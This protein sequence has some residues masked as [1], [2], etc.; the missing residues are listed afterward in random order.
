MKNKI[1]DFRLYLQ[2]LGRLR[3]I[4]IALAILCLTVSIL[5]PTVRWLSGPGSNYQVEY[6]LDG[7]ELVLE[8]SNVA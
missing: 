5:V 7:D 4:G 6:P 3:V 8:G 2:G 1:F